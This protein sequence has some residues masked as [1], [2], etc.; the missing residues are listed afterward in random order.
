M[1]HYTIALFGE[2]EKG[3]FNTLLPIHDL[4]QLLSKLGQAPENS[5]GIDFAV[6][7]L[8]YKHTV[9]FVRVENEGFSRADYYHGF[10]L[11]YT[12]KEELPNLAALCLPGVGDSEIIE[13]TAPILETTNSFLMTTEQD[14]YDYL[15][16]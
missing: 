16:A 7:A 6:Q 3:A 13:A 12:S 14:L 2:A 11:L 9:L 4:E 5:R 1:S 10:K 15:T 8:L